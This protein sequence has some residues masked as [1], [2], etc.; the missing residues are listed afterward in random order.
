[1]YFAISTSMVDQLY[2]I[3][4]C[5]V[6][7]CYFSCSSFFFAPMQVV[8]VSFPGRSINTL[9]GHRSAETKTTTSYSWYLCNKTLCCSLKMNSSSFCV[10]SVLLFNRTYSP[11]SA[12]TSCVLT[13]YLAQF[14]SLCHLLLTLSHSL[15]SIHLTYSVPFLTSYLFRHPVFSHLYPSIQC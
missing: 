6:S 11:V 7:Q 2:Q 10:S 9:S 8:N 15:P 14:V 13:L 4:E 3:W 12:I 5:D 1:M